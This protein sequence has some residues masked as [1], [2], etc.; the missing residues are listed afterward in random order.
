MGYSPK[1]N[2]DKQDLIQDELGVLALPCWPREVLASAHIN[3]LMIIAKRE[4]H[5]QNIQTVS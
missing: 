5:T 2:S 4:N 3:K 1:E